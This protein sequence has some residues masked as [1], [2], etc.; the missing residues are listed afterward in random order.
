M[1]QAI[2]LIECRRD[3]PN[4]DESN[5][6]TRRD[7]E[8]GPRPGDS[9]GPLVIQTN[10]GYRQVGIVSRS[11]PGR[12]YIFTSVAYGRDWIVRATNNLS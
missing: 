4:V 10:Q 2:T 8:Q 1:D 3:W 11:A 5:I 12:A 7:G 9:G 6:C